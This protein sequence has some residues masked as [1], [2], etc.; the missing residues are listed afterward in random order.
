MVACRCPVL[1]VLTGDAAAD[2]ARRHLEEIRRDGMGR[3]SYRCPDT[4]IGWTEE[5]PPA[6]YGDEPRKLRRSSQ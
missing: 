4:G 3:A 2:Y 5:R 1:N 6:G